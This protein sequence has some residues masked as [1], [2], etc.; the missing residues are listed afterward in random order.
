MA[1]VIRKWCLLIVVV[2]GVL[3]GCS[4]ERDRQWYKPN[5][6]YTV[7]E[8]NRDRD[9]CTGKDNVR[10]E[11]IG[12]GYIGEEAFRRILCH[13]KL[14]GKTFIAETPYDDPDDDERNVRALIKLSRPAR[15]RKRPAM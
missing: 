5:T 4:S 7:A 6:N 10:H 15:S 12:K 8:F 11:H 9:A 14:R 2:S 13:P 1:A 3:V